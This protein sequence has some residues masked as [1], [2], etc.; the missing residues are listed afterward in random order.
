MNSKNNFLATRRHFL[1]TTCVAG[2]VVSASML[3]S[4]SG[5]PSGGQVIPRAGD[6]G[7]TTP[8]KRNAKS[9]GDRVELAPPQKQP[10]NLTLPRLTDRKIGFAIVGLGLLSL[11]ELLPAFAETQH[12]KC[13]A[14]VSGHRDK[15]LQVAEYYGVSKD[16]IYD[17]ENFNSIAKNERVDVIYIVL[18][19][20]MHAE[21]TIR[22]F[23][24]G[25]HMLCEKP[26][27]VTIDECESMITAG[28]KANRK[29]MI[30]YRLHYEPM[31][32][33]AAKWCKDKKFGE[34]RSISSANCQVVEA[35]NI[36]LSKRLG[37]GPLGDIGIYSIN[38]MRYLTGEEPVRVS[39]TAHSPVDDPRFE[40]VPA[41]V[42]FTL[43]FPSGV[44]AAGTC[45][46]NAGVKRDFHIHCKDA[47]IEMD[48]AFS[49]RGLR[50]FIDSEQERTQ[51]KI[52]EVNHFVAEMDHFA[53]CIKEDTVPHTTGAEGLK[54]IKIITA[55]NQAVAS[56]KTVEV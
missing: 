56:G 37:G 11:E 4:S 36:R 21:F 17:Y 38:A 32:L 46:F 55:I 49:Y 54:D 25:K 27:A 34:V 15:A 30:A 22:G 43:E 42:A 52:P 1:T 39:A 31:N 14:L 48:P 13:V 6:D 47:T 45:S 18:P 35:P 24:A 20:S 12:S 33:Q 44:L 3:S 29:L 7:V 50:L 51:F 9:A 53:V 41:T 19:N 28:E 2:S 8:V 23:E 5:A 16:A 26:M 10:E 40:E